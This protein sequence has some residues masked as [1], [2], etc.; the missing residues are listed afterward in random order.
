MFILLAC[1]VSKIWPSVKL[2]PKTT[3]CLTCDCIQ[4]F[5]EKYQQILG[6][7]KVKTGSMYSCK[8]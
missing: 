2:N 3:Y 4:Y 8:Y 6:G 1:Q 5:L 7:M